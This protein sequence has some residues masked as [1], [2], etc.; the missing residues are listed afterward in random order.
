MGG[1]LLLLM[2]YV[3]FAM[4]ECIFL[5]KCCHGFFLCLTLAKKWFASFLSQNSTASCDP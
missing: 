4:F 3:V 5:E 1:G 2:W